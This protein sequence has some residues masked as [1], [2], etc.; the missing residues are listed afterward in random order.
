MDRIFQKD[1][2]IRER[3]M[4]DK[5]IVVGLKTSLRGD[6][7]DDEGVSRNAKQLHGSAQNGWEKKR[8]VMVIPFGNVAQHL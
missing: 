7:V 5:A 2:Q 1:K 8:R 6:G 3:Q 4:I